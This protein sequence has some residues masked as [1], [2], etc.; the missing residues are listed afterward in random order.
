MHLI[1]KNAIIINPDKVKKGSLEI[2]GKYIENIK[3]EDDDFNF[4]D[5]IESIDLDGL[6]IMAGGIDA[7]VHFR[8]PGMTNKADINTESKAAVLGGITSFMDMPNTNPPAVSLDGVKSKY[9]LAQ[10]RS[11][12]NYGFHIGA[13]NTNYDLL[14]N[15]PHNNQR[16]FAGI[17]VFLGAS[18]GNMLV[19]NNSSIDN[20]FSIRD[21]EIMIHSEDQSLIEE[22]MKEAKAQF[23][24]NIPFLYH[25]Y[26]RSRKAC[27]KSTAKAL[28]LAIKHMTRLHILHVTTKEEIE[29]I[30]AAK[31]HNPLITAETSANYLWFCDQ[32]YEKLG[33]LI[34]CNPAIKTKEDRA[35][36]RKAILDGVI[37]T[38]GSD[39]AP[40]LL[41]EKQKPYISCPS[42]I[43]SIGQS[44]S[45]ILTIASQDNIPL[46][47]VSSLMS[48]KVAE[49]FKIDRRGKLTPGAYADIVVFNP[50][51][52]FIV[53]KDT[54]VSSS[55]GIYYKCKWSPYYGTK[56]RGSIKAVFVNGKQISDSKG[57]I[58]NKP[59][60][61]QLIFKNN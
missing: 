44:L 35:A 38:I 27:I 30:R 16:D 13:T 14:K 24:E 61:E 25:P 37:D 50:N 22:G 39:H 4:K 46:S 21:I 1:L 34:K 48:G 45:V 11:F 36:L 17:K 9:L 40:H 31:L 2:K 60:G 59:F 10:N 29:M 57:L 5:N 47:R 56:L 18:T 58:E 43:P 28:D 55:A 26:I 19:D 7:H 12:C 33:G 8:E 42:G 15:L 53:G 6:A 20:I 23:G 49:M 32:D 51:E 52:E 54:T 41:E 3:Y